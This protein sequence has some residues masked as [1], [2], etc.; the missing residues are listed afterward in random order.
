MK[1]R[2]L[3]QPP[4]DLKSEISNV[5]VLDAAKWNTDGP[6]CCEL[7]QDHFTGLCFDFTILAGPHVEMFG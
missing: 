1:R 3:C 7:V 2:R 6:L 5:L 4:T